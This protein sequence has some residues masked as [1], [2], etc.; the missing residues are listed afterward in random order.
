MTTW[1]G[2]SRC[3]ARC[4]ACRPSPTS[5]GNEAAT[6]RLASGGEL[7]CQRPRQAAQQ[8]QL[9]IELLGG[10]PVVAVVAHPAL[11][12]ETQVRCAAY[13]LRFLFQPEAGAE[14]EFPDQHRF[15]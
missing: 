13:Q 5:R 11:C 14:V 4:W 3:R 9:A 8:R 12:I 6:R 2:A 1:S 10:V 15:A 7:S